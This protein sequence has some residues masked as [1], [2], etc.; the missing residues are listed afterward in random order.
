MEGQNRR[1][2][3][4]VADLFSG[5]AEVPTETAWLWSTLS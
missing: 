1:V 2:S 3:Y 5:E 4:K